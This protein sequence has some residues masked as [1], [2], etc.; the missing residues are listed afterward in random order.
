MSLFSIAYKNVRKNLSFYALYLFSVAFIL[1]IFFC[2]VSFSMNN[3]MMEKISQDGRVETMTNVISV[4]LMA[5]VIFYMSYSNNF[6]MRRR[7]KE[8][9]VYTLLGYRKSAILKLLTT[10]NVLICLWAFLIGIVFGAA[11]HKGIVAGIVSLLDLNIDQS[12]IPFFNGKAIVYSAFFVLFVVLALSISNWH[13]L[14][15][16][17][18]L[19]LVRLEKAGDK[20]LKIHMIPAILGVLMMAFGDILAIDSIREKKSVWYTIGV[21][22]VGLLVVILIGLGTTLFIYSF[23]PYVMQHLQRRKS[24]LYKPTAIV[25]IPKF[26]HRIRTNARTL[27]MLSLLSAAT[28][29]VFGVSALSAYYPIAATARIIPSAIEFR[30]ESPEQTQQ[31][32]QTLND[33]IGKGNFQSMETDIIKVSASSDKLPMEYSISKDKGRQPGFE[34]ISISDYNALI[35]QQGKK[36]AYGKLDDAECILVKY[37]PDSQNTDV[38]ST[39]KMNLSSTQTLDVSVKDTTLENPI[40]FSNSVGT[41]VVSDSVYSRLAKAQLPVTKVMSIDGKGFRDTKDAYEAVQPILKNNQYFAC[42]YARTYEIKYAGSSTFLLLG[43]LTV[44]FFIASG[45]I[46]HFH[47]ISAITYDKSDYEILSKIGYSR[48]RIKAVIRKQISAVYA[49]PFVLG[50]IHAICGM[51]CYKSLLMD[52]ILG[53]SSQMILPVLLSVVISALIYMIYYL[54]TKRSCYRIALKS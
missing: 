1:T 33:K 43:F 35:K 19:G 12:Q 22:P 51:F 41:L 44:L 10:E 18:L 6:F 24:M 39:Y 16:T 11:A 28:L 49:I 47:N 31:A 9:G 30:L 14:H 34:V 54:V 20:K 50:L 2:F 38:G 36:N 8:L 25:T 40:G 26:V 52:D 32:I 21:S 15:K 23:L 46:L 27:T 4:F 17:S 5:F 29:C 42:A 37:R 53:Q 3:V 48:H 13:L 7:M 45:S